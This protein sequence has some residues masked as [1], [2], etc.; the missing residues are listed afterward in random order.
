MKI[1]M[2]GYLKKYNLVRFAL[3]IRMCLHQRLG[4]GSSPTDIG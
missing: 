1:N 3:G 2:L 4:Y